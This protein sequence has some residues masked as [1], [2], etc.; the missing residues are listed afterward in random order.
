MVFSDHRKYTPGAHSLRATDV[1]FTA[2]TALRGGALFVDAD[3]STVSF[4][5]RLSDQAALNRLTNECP[6]YLK[7]ERGDRRR[8]RVSTSCFDA[9]AY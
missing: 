6:L 1:N 3:S 5:D 9:G 8:A 7:P 2:N 4:M